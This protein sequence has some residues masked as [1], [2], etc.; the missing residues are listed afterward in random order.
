MLKEKQKEKSMAESTR[1]IDREQDSCLSIAPSISY[2]IFQVCA[3]IADYTDYVVKKTTGDN[4]YSFDEYD[5]RIDGYH[6][7]LCCKKNGVIDN[8]CFDEH[9]FYQGKDLIGFNVISF[10]LMINKEP[11][12]VDID[13]VPTKDE[14]HGQNHRCYCFYFNR[15]R[16]IQLWTWRKRI[17]NLTV[18]DYRL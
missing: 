17:V 6:I 1:A 14:N 16:V 9:C 4:H 8:I 18:Y 13:W 3:N 5:A 2:G 15:S 11:D 7:T 12:S 10:M